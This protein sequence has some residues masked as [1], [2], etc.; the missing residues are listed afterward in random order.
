MVFCR[1]QR[2]KLQKKAPLPGELSAKLTERLSQ[3]WYD[4][5]VSASP[6]HLPWEGRPWGTHSNG[7][8]YEG[9]LSPEATDEVGAAA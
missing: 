5:S 1:K 7:F 8:P 4:L 6:S 2:K 9:K 3:I